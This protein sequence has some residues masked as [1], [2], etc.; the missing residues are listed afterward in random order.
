MVLWRTFS[1]TK[2]DRFV[3]FS[4]SFVAARTMN[5][6]KLEDFLLSESSES[7]SVSGL[8]LVLE[9]MKK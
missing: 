6:G 7:V 2:G 4:V 8:S 3:M 9:A 5:F 1:I